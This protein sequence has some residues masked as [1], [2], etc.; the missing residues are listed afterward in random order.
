FWIRLLAFI[1]DWVILAIIGGVLG[2]AGAFGVSTI[3]G[4]VYYIGFWGARGQTIGMMPF[5]LRVVR[6][7]NG[8]P[9]TWSNAILRYIGL[10]ISV[11]VIFIGVIWV[12]FDARKRGW[13]D[14]IGGTVVVRP[15]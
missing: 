12:A 15:Q 6:N 9:I 4:I 2:R 8:M 10:I 5:N 7:D 1:I 3:I 14:M 11:L 13:H